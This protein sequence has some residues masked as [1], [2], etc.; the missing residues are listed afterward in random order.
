V[1]FAA[2][3][4]SPLDAREEPLTFSFFGGPLH[5]LGR[6]LGLVRGDTTTVWLGLALGGGMWIMGAAL[7]LVG[8]IADRTMESPAN[9]QDSHGGRYEQVQAVLAALHLGEGPSALAPRHERST[10]EPGSG[11]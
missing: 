7:A 9:A 5:Q 4:D 11:P 3:E 6:R 8:G 1:V 2:S 10:R